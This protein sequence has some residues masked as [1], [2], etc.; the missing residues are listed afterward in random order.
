MYNYE[1]ITSIHIEITS[2]CQARCPMCPRR[3][4]GGAMNP[5][6]DLEE[7][8]L[9]QFKDWFPVS[10][11]QQLKYIN[12]CGNLGDPIAAKDTLEIIEFLKEVHPHIHIIMHTNGSA[13]TVEWW[14]RL[15]RLGVKVTFGID[16]LA[17]THHLYRISTDWNKIITNARA[18]IDAGGNAEWHM[19]VFEHNE[20]QIEECRALSQEYKFSSFSLKHTTRFQSGQ[21]NVLDDEGKT[22]HILKP[23]TRSKEMILK[24]AEAIKEIKPCITCKVKKE[25][26][27]YVS[28]TG[29]VAPCCW[30]DLKWKLHKEDSRIDYMDRIG[31]FPSL[32]KESLE[33]IFRSGYF[34][35]I[36]TT[37]TDVPLKE[38]SK[39]CGSF[40]RLGEQYVD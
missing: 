20:H 29:N 35:E 26:Q 25:K 3:I 28:A 16:G 39:Q 14:E 10:F 12:F 7:I 21:F 5:L 4:N 17:D 19:L 6:F 11:I 30:L 15:A 22:T 36:E 2:K 40:D 9:D 13:R 38:C 24:V 32:H 34:N 23:T 1:D 37:W 18:F 27:I 8:T 33:E 31:K